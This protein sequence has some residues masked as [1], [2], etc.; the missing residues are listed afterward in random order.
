MARFFFGTYEHQLDDKNRLRIPAK[1][2][3]MLIGEDGDKTYC[4]ARGLVDG[5]IY[6]FPEDELQILLEK[7]SEEKIG[8][9]SLA[10][11]LFYGSVYDAEEDPQGRVVLPAKLKAAAGIEK[12]IVTV[13]RGKRIE[14]WAADVYEK[15]CS[16]VNYRS[17]F[18]KLR[19]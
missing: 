12:D 14:I 4:F 16:D 1:F 6:V 10:T 15:M 13:G 5:C 8:E 7:L 19:I 17:E 9:A 11:M 18:K 3:K 2:R